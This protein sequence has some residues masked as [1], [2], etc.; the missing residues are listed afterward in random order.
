MDAQLSSRNLNG[1]DINI[2]NDLKHEEGETLI[3]T[4]VLLGTSTQQPCPKGIT[5]DTAPALLSA[6]RPMKAEP[7]D[8][9]QSACSVR[10]LV[11]DEK[12]HKHLQLN[13]LTDHKTHI[14]KVILM[15]GSNYCAIKVNTPSSFDNEYV[16]TSS[17]TTEN[18]ESQKF[19]SFTLNLGPYKNNCIRYQ[20][21]DG[22]KLLK[23]KCTKCDFFP[24]S[25]PA[26]KKHL[27]TAHFSELFSCEQC[28]RLFLTKILFKN[29]NYDHHT[30]DKHWKCKKCDFSSYQ[31]FKFKTHMRAHS[32]LIQ[33]SSSECKQQFTR[34]RQ[35]HYHMLKE[36]PDEIEASNFFPRY[37]CK[38][39]NLSF[40]DRCNREKH[41]LCKHFGVRPFSCK[42]CPYTSSRL[43]VVAQ[44]Q[45]IRHLH[46]AKLR[47][48]L[49]TKKFHDEKL[50]E[51]H[52][53]LH[54]FH[55]C[56]FCPFKASS[57]RL[58]CEHGIEAHNKNIKLYKCVNCPASF[59]RN[60]HLN[61]HNKSSMCNKVVKISLHE[62]SKCFKKFA[63]SK[64]L[65]WHTDYV[66][67]E[68][69]EASHSRKPKPVDLNNPILIKC[70]GCNEQF[71]KEK[72][73]KRHLQFC[74]F[75]ER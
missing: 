47:C 4:S 73:F 60:S 21:N 5:S 30:L 75:I 56:P 18:A 25:F 17:N 62:C 22:N 26:L 11:S 63:N 10:H 58:I 16:S 15:S 64:K 28:S 66:F 12:F 27:K 39:C 52:L 24:N 8:I 33:C 6:N 36:H 14:T 57:Q 41:V 70:R 37:R 69:Q 43:H 53:K 3:K 9:D 50:L 2:H 71:S 45:L 55:Q 68:K 13:E 51:D 32:K 35:V 31:N 67:C 42:Y 23:L 61:R 44:H 65:K 59:T 1:T 20:Q 72:V 49:C 74:A 38:I 40:V 54:I 46:P 34:K 48:S 7:T 29:H 19:S